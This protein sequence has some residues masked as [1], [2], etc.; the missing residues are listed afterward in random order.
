MTSFL[1]FSN[2]Y[3]LLKLIKTFVLL[4]VQLLCFPQEMLS[5]LIQTVKQPEKGKSDIEQ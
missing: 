2:C 1:S 4:S 3:I 5:E